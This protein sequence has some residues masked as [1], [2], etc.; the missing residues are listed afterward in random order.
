MSNDL[1]S[2]AQEV[3]GIA[4]AQLLV[5]LRF[6]DRALF[7][8]KL[9]ENDVFPLATDGFHLL[10]E[11]VSLLKGYRQQQSFAVRGYLHVLLHCIFRH[12]FVSPFVEQSLWNLACDMAVQALMDELNL[13]Q[14]IS[15]TD[16]QS[17]SVVEQLR[18]AVQPLTAEKIYRWLQDEAIDPLMLAKWSDLFRMDDHTLWY[19]LVENSSNED[20][21]SD[22]KQAD[23]SDSNRNKSSSTVEGNRDARTEEFDK[24]SNEKEPTENSASNKIDLNRTENSGSKQGSSSRVESRQAQAQVWKDI[25]ERMQ[26]DLETFSKQQGDQAG[27]LLQSLR[28]INREKTDYTTFLR[29]FASS[30][31]VMKLSLDEFDYI[32]YTYGLTMY[33]DMPLVEPL[34][35]RDDKRIRNFVIAIDTSGSVQGEVVQQFL[36]KTYNIL[37]KEETF[38]RR[39]NLH[40][41]QCDAEVQEDVVIHTQDEFDAYIRNMQLRGFG[42]TSFRPVF[43]YVEKLRR[44][45]LLTWL[46]GLI[47]FTD[48][49][50][51]YPAKPTSYKTAFVFLAEDLYDTSN[52]PPWAIRAV[53]EKDTLVEEKHRKLME[54]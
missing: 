39:F 34:E 24:N 25:S 33:K 41:I 53:I 22:G 43:E 52:V 37:K 36:Q 42:G 8:L 20:E 31:E 4:K 6:L 10:Y 1:S 28:H 54:L 5:K 50:G 40:L 46:D 12:M 9:L 29:K 27:S 13:P 11:P 49:Y 2:I 45:K 14:L 3:L 32:F 23:T 38:A 44:E 48:G 26:T 35:Y 47:Y 51:T 21:D 19:T 17:K 15:E 16:Q 7:E 18:G 30:C